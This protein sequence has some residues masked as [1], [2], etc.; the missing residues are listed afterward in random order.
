[1]G[2]QDG[3]P[4]TLTRPTKCH[5]VVAL[6]GGCHHH[7]FSEKEAQS[8]Q[9]VS[10]RHRP[11]CFDIC[12]C[13]NMQ[14]LTAKSTDEFY[15]C[16]SITTAHESIA[17]TFVCACSAGFYRRHGTG[18]G[19]RTGRADIRF[20]AFRQDVQVGRGAGYGATRELAVCNE[21]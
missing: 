12:D 5:H 14:V 3:V 16:L 19:G 8:Q 21:H 4:P 6:I 11:A 13:A 10:T 9:Q 1:M 15:S 7:S 17:V 18:S 20:D 2:C